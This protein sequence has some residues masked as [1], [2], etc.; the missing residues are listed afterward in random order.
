MAFENFPIPSAKVSELSAATLPLTGTESVPIVQGGLTVKAPASAFGGLLYLSQGKATAAPNATVPVVS[1]VAT[2]SETDIDFVL[3]PKG[4]GGFSLQVADNTTAGGN[5]RNG[6]AVDL[7]L[8][9]ET[10]AEVAS[11]Y[12]SGIL[13][14]SSNTASGAFAVV[15]G[16]NRNVASGQNSWVPGGSAC[17]ADAGLSTASGGFAT[18]RGVRGVEA[19]GVV[20]FTSDKGSRQRRKFDM[21]NRTTNATPANLLTDHLGGDGILNINLPVN[22]S[23][24]LVKGVV[25]AIASTSFDVK[26]WEFSAT[27]KRG[28]G[29]GTVAIIG[30]PILTVLDADSGAS[31]WDVDFAA[32]TTN[33]YFNIVVTGEAAKTISWAATV[34]T[35]ESTI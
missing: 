6:K 14:G 3:S 5:K 28:A 9:R 19:H 13:S 18:A 33:G 8:I 27:V 35:T 10:A 1:L 23:L 34:E 17:L 2:G 32:D 31:A 21:S 11:G 30:T 20:S 24:Y 26:T 25:T 29:V 16:G 15:V 7:Q 22:G 4:Q 12:F